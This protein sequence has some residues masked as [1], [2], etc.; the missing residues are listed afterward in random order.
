[1]VVRGLLREPGSIVLERM[2]QTLPQSVTNGTA[3]TLKLLASNELVCV[4][5]AAT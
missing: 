2:S 3:A 4:V 5:W 1:M